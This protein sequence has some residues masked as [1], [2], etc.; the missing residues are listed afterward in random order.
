[1]VKKNTLIVWDGIMA[2]TDTSEI[3]TYDIAWHGTVFANA[4]SVDASS[5]KAPARGAFSEFCES[6]MQFRVR[7]VARSADGSRDEIKFKPFRMNLKDGEGWDLNGRKL[8]DTEHELF[9]ENLRWR[10][11]PDQKDSL[12]FARGKDR[13]G[14]F[15]S[16][17]WMRPGNRVTMARRYV[18]ASD[19][20]A[21]WSIQKLRAEVLEQI[22]D[23]EEEEAM[24]PPWTCDVFNARLCWFVSWE[25]LLI[26]LVILVC[27]HF[28]VFAATQ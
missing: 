7:G 28:V 24:I 8:T 1:M 21:N 25:D 3:G 9:V 16:V 27:S 15:V 2:A 4:H 18:D 19:D 23:E 20:R 26:P 5:V 17:G 13:F 14:S 11:S 12:V 6:P 22:Y 10:G